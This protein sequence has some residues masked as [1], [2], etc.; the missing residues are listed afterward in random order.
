VS[1][2]AR[3]IPFRI[4]A[5]LGLA[6]SLVAD[7]ANANG[8][9][10]T[11]GQVVVAPDNAD[12]LYLRTT[13]GLLVSKD[14]GATW[15]WI[16]ETAYGDSTNYD[17]TIGVTAAE[18][19]LVTLPTGL[20]SSPDGCAW[21]PAPGV[22][23]HAITDLVVR[24]DTPSA[25]LAVASDYVST[26]AGV[27][28]FA[29]RVYATANDGASWSAIG[30]PVT[31]PVLV[32]TIEVAASDD[33][34]IYLSA[35][36]GSGTSFEEMILTSTDTGATW[37]QADVPAVTN[38]LGVYLAAVDPSD[39]SRVYV[40]TQNVNAGTTTGRLLVSSDGAATFQS[41]YS[42]GALLGFALSPDGGEVF[43]GGLWPSDGLH[44]AP[45]GS[46]TFTQGAA[47]SIECLAASGGA[48]YA[49]GDAFSGFPFGVSNDDGATFAHIL[50]FRKIRGPLAC[51]SDSAT[52][53]CAAQWPALVAKLGIVSADGGEVAADG[54][55]ATPDA[56]EDDAGAV[57][58]DGGDGGTVTVNTTGDWGSGCGA[59]PGPSSGGGFVTAASLLFAVV[60]A[61]GARGKA[62]QR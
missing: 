35:A 57:D 6:L 13:F 1:R 52:A 24:R 7:H 45:S 36:R 28:S 9:Y 54:G 39:E 56:G 31:P 32:A 40:R 61:L 20:W 60:A 46:L 50:D 44:S 2:R 15:D 29:S 62:R 41:V 51:P 25:A 53:T 33:A 42:G 27:S 48:L 55:V 18:T 8:R 49:C 43:V 11:A 14:R 34:R 23:A 30:A 4:G 16:C 26:D 59:A 12:H 22:G 5:L 47:I 10:P 38:D 21:G 3:R 58:A 19:I 37:T 17:A